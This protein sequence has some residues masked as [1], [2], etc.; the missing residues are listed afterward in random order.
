MLTNYLKT[1][2]RNLLRNKFFTLINVSGLAIGLAV[3]VMIL[4]WVDNELSYDRFHQHASAIYAI[5]ARVG[6]GSGEQVWP[7]T[8]A[9]LAVFCRQSI[10]EVA[11]VVRICPRGDQALVSFGDKKF[12][13][14]ASAYIDPSFFRIFSFDWIEGQ[15]EHPFAD[16]HSII[17]TQSTAKKFFGDQPAQG[18]VLQIGNSPFRITGVLKD[19]PENSEIRYDMLFPLSLYAS[20]FQGNGD[21]KTIDEDLGN[22]FYTTY[23]LLKAGSSP[24][25]VAVKLTQLYRNKRK[26]E[27]EVQHN[28]FE[29]Q[30]LTSRHL[31]TPDGNRSALQMV[32]IFFLVAVIILIIACINYVNLATARSIIR[33]REVS[34]RKIIGAA[35]YQLFLQFIAESALLFLLASILAVL[36]IY[37]LLPTYNELSGI[38]LTISF[39]ESRVWMVVAFAVG[40][41]LA[42]ASVYPALLLSSF[43]PIQTLKGKLSARLGTITFRKV[44][45][46]T[47]FVFSVGLIIS[48]LVVSR[49]LTYLR[50]K[51][52][53]FDKE[54]VFSFYLRGE[55]H[56]HFEAARNDLMKQPGILGVGV[57]DNALTNLQG[58][59]T[60]DAQ[61]DGKQAGRMFIV[62]VNGIDK[63]LIPLLRMQMTEGANYTGS[64]ADS[65]HFILN[66]TAIRQAGIHD[67]VGKPFSLWGNKGTIIGVMKD[68]NYASLRMP[69]EPVVF[70]YDRTGWCVFVKTTARDASK[71]IAAARQVWRQYTPDFPF[72]YSF[73]DDEF[74]RLYDSDQ[75]TAVLFRSFAV[76]AVLICCLGLVGLAT[77]TAQMRTKEIGI[78]KVLGASVPGVI[79]LLAREFV[80]L[81]GMGIVIAAPI[82]WLAMNSWLQQYAYRTQISGWIFLTAGLVAILLTIL[83]VSFQAVR[84]ALA[85]P[86]SSL[87]EE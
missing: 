5:N 14:T 47:Q 56:D 18:K 83:T 81:V 38:H 49:Q 12:P 74:S 68:F 41:S 75:R 39:T 46:V 4:L 33:S 48:T 58:N 30:P 87:R 79:R 16:N 82:A 42:L 71:A 69:L 76:I 9:P 36:V 17:L 86:V 23:L 37:L 67:P 24:E 40:G 26:N 61:W 35:K 34:V 57:S 78:R 77:Y 11:D 60:G 28:S 1:A 21:W 54:Q 51:D 32:Q 55:M 72:S 44:L 10:P 66:E 15:R 43:Q 19:F 31:V 6:A 22:Y 73:L 59:S 8:P 85:N 2:W 45:V 50:D 70:Y 25:R 62:H 64:P 13:E 53:G 80:I 3:G 63:D 27:P 20:Q 52:L 65:L 7:G 84:A 29:L